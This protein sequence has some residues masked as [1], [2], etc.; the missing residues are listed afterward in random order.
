MDAFVGSAIFSTAYII[1]LE[2]VTAKYRTIFGILL[3]CIYA[4]GNIYLG[5]VAM[6]FKNYKIILISCYFPTFFAIFYFRYLPQ[7]N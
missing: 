5:V 6:F 3:N 4:F 7:S 2:L 1:A